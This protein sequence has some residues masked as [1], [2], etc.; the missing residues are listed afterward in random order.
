MTGSLWAIAGATVIL[1]GLMSHFMT[2][3]YGWGAAVLL[4]VLALAAMIG[5]T[6]QEAGLDMAGGIGLVREALVFA[7]P[8]LGGACIGILLAL[9]RRA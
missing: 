2:R 9:W 3:R 8:I 5:M 4:P 6:W 1:A 7:A